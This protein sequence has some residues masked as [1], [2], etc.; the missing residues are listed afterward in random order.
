M[1]DVASEI[2]VE[3]EHSSIHSNPRTILEVRRGIL[4][5]HLQ[6][7]LINTES[8]NDL[9]SLSPSCIWQSQEQQLPSSGCDA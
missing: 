2:S 6:S 4:L 3:A 9:C 8:L 7:V 1:D 5:E